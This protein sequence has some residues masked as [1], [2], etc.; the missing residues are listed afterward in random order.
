MVLK[1]WHMENYFQKQNRRSL[2]GLEK[3]WV[4]GH[5]NIF[6]TVLVCILIH[7]NSAVGCLTI[8]RACLAVG[9]SWYFQTING[10]L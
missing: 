5:F 7:S 2:L 9:V 8:A 4:V 1:I 6:L 3:A 10:F